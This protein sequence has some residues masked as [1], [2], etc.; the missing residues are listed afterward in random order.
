MTGYFL[1]D[2]AI[3]AISLFNTILLLWLGL[4]VL[5]SAERRSRGVWLLGGGLLLGAGFFISHTAILGHELT[6]IGQG[7][8]FWWRLGWIPVIAAPLTWY[9]MILWYAGYWSEQGAELR[10]R[11]C[12]WLILVG[13]LGAMLVALMFFTPSLP[14]FTQVAQLDLST[15][16]VVAGLPLLFIIYPIFNVLCISLSI[17]VLLHPAPSNR[18]MGDIARE[19][20]QPWLMAAATTLLVVSA[21]VAWFMLW[22]VGSARTGPLSVLPPSMVRSAVWIDLTV[23]SLIGL[24]ALFIGQAIVSYEVFTGKTLP[25]RG[26]FRHWRSAVILALGYSVVIGWSLASRLRPIYSLLLT[27][28][29]MVAFYALF[30]WR[31]FIERDRFMAHLRPFVSSQELTR[32][33]INPSDTAPTRAK[34]IF[35]ALCQDIL[36]V[37]QAQLFPMGTLA[38]LAGPPLVYPPTERQSTISPPTANFLT[39]PNVSIVP[40]HPERH[41]GL[42]WG[43]PL[44]AERGLVGVLLLGDKQ[45]NGLFTQEEIEIARAGGERIV[46]MLTGEEMARRLMALQR[47]RLTETRVLD[48]RT[49]RALH[50]EVLPNL[51]TAVLHLSGLKRDA[52]VVQETVGMLTDIHRR[53]SD[54]IRV[55]PGMLSLVAG[56]GH[57]VGALKDMLLS[58]FADEFETVSWQVHDEPPH[59]DPLS[60]E[61]IFYAVREAVRNAALHGR[62][63][64]PERKLNL[65]ITVCCDD[66]LTV[67]VR[68]DGVGLLGHQTIANDQGGL[69]LHSTMVA[70]VGGH[71]TVDSVP[72]GGTQA[73]ITVPT[74]RGLITTEVLT[75]SPTNP[76]R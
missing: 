63:N 47:R 34:S 70:I 54:L 5:L 69:A 41:D 55:H 4:T 39:L 24:A 76:A 10:R 35:L 65:T 38:P 17:D 40:L 52:P 60:E 31:S 3:I 8:N 72:E 62:G 42:K 14:S 20:T 48:H 2:W 22:V 64:E 73:T 32:H 28:M 51:H 15:G 36:N 25:R 19:R 9:G 56:E 11:Q 75:G 13:V 58:E 53:I 66:R 16:L 7:L 57:L 26:F 27:T 23:E 12:P 37:Q 21:L 43:I 1:L 30:G 33:L 59:L 46:D 18:M 44:W 68:D 29:L 74:R 45:D 49:R 61:V 71:L 67:S 6:I 50:D